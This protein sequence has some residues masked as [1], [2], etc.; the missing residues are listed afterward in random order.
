MIT[1]GT[2]TWLRELAERNEWRIEEGP[3]IFGGRIAD[4]M[5]ERGEYLLGYYAESKAATI[6]GL[7]RKVAKLRCSK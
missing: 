7:A 4:L 2:V 5:D 6:R 1:P 3:D